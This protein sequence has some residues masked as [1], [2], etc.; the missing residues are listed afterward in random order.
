MCKL[1]N[2]LVASQARAVRFKWHF[3]DFDFHAC[4]KWG[5]FRGSRQSRCRESGIDAQ[6]AGRKELIISGGEQPSADGDLG[7]SVWQFA[8]GPQIST[9]W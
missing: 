8:L 3:P 6:P 2:H 7:G 4:Q 1:S 9:G 5:S